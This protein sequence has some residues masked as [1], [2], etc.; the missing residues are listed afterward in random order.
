[1]QARGLQ[2][3]RRFGSVN[4]KTSL[5]GTSEV[6]LVKIRPVILNRASDV[7]ELRLRVCQLE[8]LRDVGRLDKD[9]IQVNIVANLI[10]LRIDKTERFDATSAPSHVLDHD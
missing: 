8:T 5:A 6:Q 3:L 10:T 4:K 1:L 9:G 7:T 2:R